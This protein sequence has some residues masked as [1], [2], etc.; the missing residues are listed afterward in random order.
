MSEREVSEQEI[1]D[2]LEEIHEGKDI[3]DVAHVLQFLGL[4]LFNLRKDFEALGQELDNKKDKSKR[5]RKN[6]NN[7][8]T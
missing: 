8:Y 6:N 3:E 1:D 5:K 4:I 2:R 7:M